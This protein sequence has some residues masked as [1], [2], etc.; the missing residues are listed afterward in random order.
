MSR[1]ELRVKPVLLER[2]PL[3]AD[4]VRAPGRGRIGSRG[5]DPPAAA[6]AAQ[7]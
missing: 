6:G 3:A 7:S 5:A 1:M 4:L 2:I